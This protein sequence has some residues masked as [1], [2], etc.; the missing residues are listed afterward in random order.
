MKHK[1]KVST[2]LQNNKQTTIGY[3][4]YPSTIVRYRM[5]MYKVGYQSITNTISEFIDQEQLTRQGSYT[6]RSSR[7]QGLINKIRTKNLYRSYTINAQDILFIHY[8]NIEPTKDNNHNGIDQGQYVENALSRALQRIKDPVLQTRLLEE[9][10]CYH[11]RPFRERLNTTK[12]TH[13]GTYRDIIEYIFATENWDQDQETP[14][15]PVMNLVILELTL[16]YVLEQIATNRI[17][18]L[19]TD[20]C[21]T[22]MVNIS[23]VHIRNYVFSDRRNPKLSPASHQTREQEINDLIQEYFKSLEHELLTKG[24]NPDLTDVKYIF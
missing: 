3:D 12:P 20:D 19:N 2:E 21:I 8:T 13:N 24:I 14:V 9:L 1:L 11:V 17:Q 16:G 6:T 10:K 22:V 15:N 18:Y 7:F 5:V 4:E 23:R